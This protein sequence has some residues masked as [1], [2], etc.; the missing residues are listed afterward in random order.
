MIDFQGPI[1][2]ANDDCATFI[3]LRQIQDDDRIEP[4]RARFADVRRAIPT[5]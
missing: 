4:R 2:C 1:G 3:R 5:R